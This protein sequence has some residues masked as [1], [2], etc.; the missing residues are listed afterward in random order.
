METIS[1]VCTCGSG[2]KIF[3]S[4]CSA[5]QMSI[6]LKNG[7]DHL[8]HENN[9]GHLCNPVWYSHLKHNRKP[10]KE[11][12]EGMVRRFYETPMVSA[13]NVIEFY[14]NGTNN[15]LYTHRL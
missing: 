15:K 11:I 3:C 13:T 2:R 8:K 12:I 14:E 5:V 10:L 7:N 9:R 1:K 4:N 6:L